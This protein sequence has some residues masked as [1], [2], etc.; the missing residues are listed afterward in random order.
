MREGEEG[1]EK[2]PRGGQ[3]NWRS[4]QKQ[5][6]NAWSLNSELI[7]AAGLSTGPSPWNPDEDREEEL[8]EQNRQ[9]HD[10]ETHR[11]SELVATF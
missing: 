8:Y 4:K 7:E 1:K 10:G 5:T 2:G 3:D 6:L 11:D 9:D